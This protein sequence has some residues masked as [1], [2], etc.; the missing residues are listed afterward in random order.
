[1]TTAGESSAK[2]ILQMNM[3]V[4]EIILIT[5][6]KTCWNSTVKIYTVI[7]SSPFF[8]IPLQQSSK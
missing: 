3:Q 7:V 1:M 8:V 4:T 5:S 2:Q 6:L